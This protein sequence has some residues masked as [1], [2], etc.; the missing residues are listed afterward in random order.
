VQTASG[1]RCRHADPVVGDLDNHVVPTDAVTT[2]S[3]ALACRT[4]LLNPSLTTAW[5]CCAESAGIA[6]TGPDI[7]TAV[8]SGASAVSALQRQR[9]LQLPFFEPRRPRQS[10]LRYPNRWPG[11]RRCPRYVRPRGQNKPGWRSGTAPT[12]GS[13]TAR[14]TSPRKTI[15]PP[16]C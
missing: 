8:R 9:Q 3:S 10:D 11:H 12:Q 14:W 5:A 1:D 7:L 13:R 2:S 16:R 6:F 4:A 15:G